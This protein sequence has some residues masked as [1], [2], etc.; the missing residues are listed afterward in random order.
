MQTNQVAATAISRLGATMTIS[1]HLYGLT[2][3][4]RALIATHPEP[5]RIRKVFEQLIDQMLVDQAFLSD[6]DLGIVLRDFA[7]TLFQPR[8]EL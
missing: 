1:T 8:V 6:P 7:A 3:A 5:E 2:S 4:V